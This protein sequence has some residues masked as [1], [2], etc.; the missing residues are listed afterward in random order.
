MT[1]PRRAPDSP[2]RASRLAAWL[3]AATLLAATL[4]VTT[5]P[6]ASA[7]PPRPLCD[8]CGDSFEATAASH[9]VDVDVERSTATVSV[10]RNG[11]ATW[12]VRNRLTDTDGLARLRANASLRAEVADRA[13]WDAE[14]LGAGVSESGVL[15]LRYREPGFAERSV[16]G[17]LRSGAFTEA[18]GY[19]N[20]DGLGADRLAVIAP[21]GMRVDWTVPGATVG[22]DGRR[23]TLTG[24]DRYGFVTFVPEGATLGPALSLLAAAS[25]LGPV[26]ATNLLTRV[27]VPTALFGAFVA[28]ACGGLARLDRR[29]ERVAERAGVALA[30][31]GA[32]V[33][34]LVLGPP[35]GGVSLLGG[36]GAPVFGVGVAAVGFGAAL[37]RPGVRERLT[38]RRLVGGAALGVVAAAGSTL[39]AA[40]AFDRNGLTLSFLTGLPP[41]V[42]VFALLPAGYALGAGDRRLA[43]ATATVGFAVSLLPFASLFTPTAQF[44][45]VV[46]L[47]AAAY[48]GAIAVVGAPLLV[49][50]VALAESSPED[51]ATGAPGGRR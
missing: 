14:F 15:T 18:H 20:L 39:A 22:D 45:P 9:G 32:L 12:A 41:L 11:T 27:A 40:V 38:Y 47:V 34:V 31:L 7:P 6:A 3:V 51:P 24:L 35:A 29:V 2:L 49:V 4:L 21:D 28:A 43:V 48:A 37:S 23:T 36:A 26:V 30:G 17:V 1:R 25:L 50:G 10:H 33:V 46:V 16:G 5:A 8:A 13:M 44:G 42:P 19:R